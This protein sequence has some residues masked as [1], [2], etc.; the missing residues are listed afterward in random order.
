VDGWI[1]LEREGVRLACL[2]LGGSG[3]PALLL[4]GLAGH[5]GE[6]AET[7]EWLSDRARVV[8]PDARGHGRSERRPP[9]VSPAA[10]VDDVVFAIEELRLGP[11]VLVGQSLGGQT[12]LLVAAKRPDLVRAL[13]VAEAGPAQGTEGTVAEVEQ[14]LARWP[15]PFASREAAVEFFGGPSLAAEMWADGLEQ[16]D[17]GWWP[18]FDVELMARTLSE[19]SGSCWEQWE[20]IRCPTLVVRAGSGDMAAAEVEAMAARLRQARVVEI[21]NAAHDLHLDRP[22]EWREALTEFLDGL[23]GEPAI[24]HVIDA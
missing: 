16:R 15:T 6:W 12:A 17:G 14:A 3:P 20:A 1:H 2:E 4:H 24:E 18:R 23:D 9:D 7:A 10:R 19:A 11:V 22:A 8:A 5:A 21:A 13:V